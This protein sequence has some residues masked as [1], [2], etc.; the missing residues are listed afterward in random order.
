MNNLKYTVWD[1]E[2]S[3]VLEKTEHLEDCHSLGISCAATMRS[4]EDHP[5]L[6]F[7]SIYGNANGMSFG[8]N[9]A[10]WASGRPMSPEKLTPKEAQKMAFYLLENQN[11]GHPIVGYNSLYFDFRVLAEEVENVEWAQRVAL[12]AFHHIDIGFVMLCDKGYMIGLDSMAKG[13]NLAGKIEGM[14]GRLAPAMWAK[15]R[16]SQDRVLEYVAQDVVTTAQVYE[17]LIGQI[18]LYWKTKSGHLSVQPWFPSIYLINEREV[19]SPVMPFKDERGRI[20]EAPLNE[21]YLEAIKRPHR[22][23]TIAECI[24]HIPLPADTSWMDKP[25]KRES[26]YAWTE[27]YL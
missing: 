10:D 18:Y 22:L 23:P 7:G 3:E 19:V 25:R 13:L 9:S 20:V 8:G 1:L 12:M 16:H 14:E 2:I 5:R 6:W 15:D 4:S 26:C 17:E 11:R 21:W 24:D 27:A